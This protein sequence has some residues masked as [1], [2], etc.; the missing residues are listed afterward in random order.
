MSDDQGKFCW[1]ELMTTDPD[2]AEAFYRKVVGWTTRDAG[3]SDRRY[4]IL[5]AG[6][7]GV[8]GLMP[9]PQAARDMGARPGWVG[10]I[11]VADADA[12]AA[13]VKQAGGVVHR[14]PEDIPNVGR[15]AVVGDP[16]GAA[17][18]LFQPGPH[19]A[20][21][22]VAPGTQGHCGWHELYVDDVDAA[23]GFYAGLFGWEKGEAMDM[24]PMGVYQIFN[25]GGTMAGGMMKRPP[26]V[27]AAFWNYYF[28]V[29]A[30]DAA[31]QRVT[32]GGG[33]VVHGPTQVPGGSWVIQCFDPQGAMVS[34]VAPRR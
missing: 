11:A 23:F 29:E 19:E 25:I 9:L 32:A 6:D 13:R 20:P 2:A 22:P 17:F 3:M 12:M 15:F 24:G 10:Y 5:N 27:P 21:P 33:T 28:N 8:G 14:A 34:L 1:Y 26:N 31:V 7:R 30:I 16:Q 4:T 18:T